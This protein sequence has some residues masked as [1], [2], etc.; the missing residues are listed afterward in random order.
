M[1][2]EKS[3]SHLLASFDSHYPAIH[4]SDP[5]K[6]FARWD[7]QSMRTIPEMEILNSYIIASVQRSGTH[8]LCTLLR[9]TG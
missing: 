1:K 4:F 6:P 5:P 7:G 3:G 2:G 9:S 8:L